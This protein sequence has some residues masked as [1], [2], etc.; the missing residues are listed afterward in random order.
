[1]IIEFVPRPTLGTALKTH[2]GRDKIAATLQKTF[3]NAFSEFL[4]RFH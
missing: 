2:S 1:M 4:L 3:S